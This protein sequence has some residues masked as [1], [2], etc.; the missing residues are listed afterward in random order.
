MTTNNKQQT[1]VRRNDPF[2]PLL[3]AGT[4][5]VLAAV[6]F[7]PALRGLLIPEGVSAVGGYSASDLLG[8]LDGGG[9]PVYTTNAPNNGSTTNSRGFNYPSDMVVD[10][11]NH[12][13][14]VTDWYN[15]RVLVFNLD[16]SNAL[17]DRTADF[18]LGQT[19]FTA[20]A[21]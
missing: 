20:N 6:V 8:Q 2:R 21:I 17:I 12:R 11:A 1:T 5:L 14:F 19:N 16:T 3:I 7:D 9:N 13:L 18:V 4:L 10:T 15:N